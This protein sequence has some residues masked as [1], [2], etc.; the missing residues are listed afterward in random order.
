MCRRRDDLLDLEKRIPDV[1]PYEDELSLMYPDRN[2]DVNLEEV[3][4]GQSVKRKSFV[5]RL[6]YRRGEMKMPARK[7]LMI[8]TLATCIALKCGGLTGE[9]KDLCGVSRCHNSEKW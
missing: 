6:D 5:T 1:S 7:R 8:G 3:L 2:L 4:R 9:S